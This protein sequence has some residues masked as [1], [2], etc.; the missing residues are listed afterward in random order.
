MRERMEFPAKFALLVLIWI[1]WWWALNAPLSSAMNLLIIVGGVLLVFPLVWLARQILD[2]QRTLSRAT[3][4]TTFVH[5]ALG[6]LFGIPIIRAI[7]THEDW[8]GWVLPIAEEIGLALVILTGAAFLLTVVNLALK[9]SGAP[10]YIALSQKLAADWLYA[11][12]RNPMVLA[13]VALLLS[14]GLWLRSA[15]FVLWALIIFA[16][17]LVFFVKVFEER[18][19][20]IRFGPSYLEYRS[21]TPMLFPRR[22]KR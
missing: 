10:F 2:R 18:E 15:L 13:G 3:W 1:S 6:L 12:T 8:A 17:A 22:P 20:E 7:L 14:V 4:M 21:R 9:G 19:L 16:P 11:W 5:A